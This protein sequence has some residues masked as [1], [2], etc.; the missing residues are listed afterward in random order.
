[1]SAKRSEGLIVGSID[2]LGKFTYNAM[3]STFTGKSLLPASAQWGLALAAMYTR[4]NDQGDRALEPF[5]NVKQ[6]VDMLKDWWGI[7]GDTPAKR[8]NQAIDVL[9]WLANEGHRASPEFAAPGDREAP[10]DLLAWDVARLVTVARHTFLAGYIE[11]EEGWAYVRDAAKMAQINFSS[12]EDYANRYNCGRIRWS[13]GPEK[14]FDDAVDFLLKSAKSPWRTLDWHLPLKDD[15]FHNPAKRY[16]KN[17]ERRNDWATRYILLPVTIIVAV[18]AAVL[19][20]TDTDINVDRLFSPSPPP[21]DSTRSPDELF[22]SIN[23]TPTQ[24]FSRM[25]VKFSVTADGVRAHF[26]NTPLP[27]HNPFAA[28]RYGVNTTTPNKSP[29]ER[30]RPLIGG[31]PMSIELPPDTRFLTIQVQFQDGTM[32]PVRRFEVPDSARR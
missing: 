30:D 29:A 22:A 26:D 8:R 16:L 4:V 14:E 5:N 31:V 21:A 2:A 18:A 17:V 32:S 20:A 19:K 3:N 23:P 25:N 28:F 7:D 1:M 13:G 11:E 10:K 12:W 24:R 6:V 9:G 15:D 27:T